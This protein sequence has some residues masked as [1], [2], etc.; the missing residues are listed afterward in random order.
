M[1]FSD[2]VKALV[3]IHGKRKLCS[4]SMHVYEF[5]YDNGIEHEL[6]EDAQRWAELACIDESYN[7]EEFDVYMK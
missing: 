3:V 5:L 1:K 7:E 2:G 4:N 6:A